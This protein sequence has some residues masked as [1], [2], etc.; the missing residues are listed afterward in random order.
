MDANEL[1]KELAAALCDLKAGKLK[2]REAKAM[3]ALAGQMIESAKVQVLYHAARREKP[4]IQF[5]ETDKPEP[6]APLSILT[7]V[8]AKLPLGRA[9]TVHMLSD[10]AP[11]K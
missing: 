1:R 8:P 2:A 9:S 6:G 11:H 7:E 3:A 5:L 10:D 4:D